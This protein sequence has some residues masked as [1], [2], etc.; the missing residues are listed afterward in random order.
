MYLLLPDYEIYSAYNDRTKSY[1]N[2]KFDFVFDHEA[3]QG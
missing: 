3:S 2:A 1:K